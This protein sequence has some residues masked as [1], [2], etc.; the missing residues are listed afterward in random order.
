VRVAVIGATLITAVFNL[1]ISTVGTL[2]EGLP[3]P[4]LPWTDMGDVLPLLIAAAGIV[5]VSLTDTIAL[6]TSFNAK[7]GEEVKPNQEMIGMGAAN[8]VAGLFQ[9]FAISAS[10]SIVSS[11]LLTREGWISS[12]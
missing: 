10:A 2:P 7:R 8:G 6:S 5:L 11:R 12:V 9:G 4:D 1:D 3:R